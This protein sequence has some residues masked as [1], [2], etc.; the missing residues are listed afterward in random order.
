MSAMAEIIIGRNPL[1]EALKA[2]RPISKILLE[3]N[4]RGH[5]QV[6][7]IVRLAQAKGVPVEYVER[8]ALN[9]QS[10]TGTHQGFWPMPPSKNM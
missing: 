4:I 1:L 3:K 6:S 10:S 7:E 2:G 5:S 8:A 9:R